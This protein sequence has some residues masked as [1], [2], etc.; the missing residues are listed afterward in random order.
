MNF[1]TLLKYVEMNRII[2]KHCMDYYLKC[3]DNRNKKLYDLDE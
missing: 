3:W 2:I 1:R